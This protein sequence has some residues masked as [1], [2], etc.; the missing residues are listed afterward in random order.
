MERKTT[1]TYTSTSWQETGQ[2][3]SLQRVV[4]LKKNTEGDR[5]EYAHRFAETYHLANLAR[6]LW[7]LNQIK[8]D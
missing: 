3:P 1:A 2:I 6:L 7:I 5:Q 4:F 8:H